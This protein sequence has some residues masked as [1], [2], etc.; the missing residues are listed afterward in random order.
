ML[1]IFGTVGEQKGC[2]FDGGE[3]A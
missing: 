1:K 2:V 3:V